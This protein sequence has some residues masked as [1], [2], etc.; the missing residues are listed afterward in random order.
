MDRK[1]HRYT[2]TQKRVFIESGLPIQI[3]AWGGGEGSDRGG[4]Q[5]IITRLQIFNNELIIKSSKYGLFLRIHGNNQQTARE[6]L[7]IILVR[8]GP[9]YPWGGGQTFGFGEKALMLGS[10]ESC[11]ATEFFLQLLLTKL[12]TK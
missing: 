4:L 11:S 7:K 6:A 9:N 1:I 12:L 10:P 2:H 8:G 3:S 5:S